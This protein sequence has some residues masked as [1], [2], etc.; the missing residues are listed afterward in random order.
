MAMKGRNTQHR[1][2]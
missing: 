1:R 2:Y